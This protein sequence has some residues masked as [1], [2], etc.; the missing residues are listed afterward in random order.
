[1]NKIG[2]VLLC[3]F[4][5]NVNLF[6]T[7]KEWKRVVI[8]LGIP[9]YYYEHTVVKCMIRRILSQVCQLLLAGY[10]NFSTP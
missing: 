8:N 1:M 4:L 9:V 7:E 3:F 6:A 2:I 10:L 5:N